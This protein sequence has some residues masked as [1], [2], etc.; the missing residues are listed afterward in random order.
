MFDG[1][2]GRVAFV[3]GAGQGIGRA[4]AERLAAEGARVCVNDIDDARA[5]AVAGEIGGFAAPFD[6]S[7]SAAVGAG[8]AA[9]E[10]ELGPIDLLVAN[11]A[12]MTMGP[13]LE[14]DPGEL[15]RHLGVNLLGTAWLIRACAP[16]M[17]GRGYGRIVAIASEWGQI[18]WP[19]A[20]EY[21]ASKGGIIALVKS[22]ARQ[23]AGAGVA[24]NAIGPGVT[25]TP[26][27]DVDAGAAGLTHEEMVG[28]YARD[29]PLGR[30]GL[31]A[32]IAATVAFLLSTP[33][34]AFVGQ[35]V[36]PNGGST[37]I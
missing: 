8:L 31:P 4:T 27:L 23:Y 32:D 16:A 13:F 2:A 21:A 37:R 20:T 24:V 7:D 10:R 6:V 26:Q 9:C 33:A 34:I 36:G 17:A 12:Y 22:V 11:H 3:S 15:G 19:E 5:R 1:I 18:G 25:D 35:V 28:V 14:Q 30:V 29:I